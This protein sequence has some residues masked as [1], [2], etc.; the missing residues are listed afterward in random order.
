MV[1]EIHQRSIFFKVPCESSIMGCRLFWLKLDNIIC[2]IKKKNLRWVIFPI[3]P[4]WPTGIS[5]F[6]CRL[7]A[8]YAL[9][10]VAWGHW[11]WWFF[12]LCSKK[13][14]K[15]K[16]V[17]FF[18]L[19]YKMVTMKVIVLAGIVS[20]SW[21]HPTPWPSQQKKGLVLKAMTVWELTRKI[22]I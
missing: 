9:N 11:N 21:K 17:C 18:S 14:N 1:C 6:K 15:Q 22:V 19:F 13:P 10:P 4:N 8:C 5:V 7:S 16:T 20:G 12:S 2:L 3:Q